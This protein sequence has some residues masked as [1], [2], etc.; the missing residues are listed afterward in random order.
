[1]ERAENGGRDGRL[2]DVPAN[3]GDA[4]GMA[5]GRHMVYVTVASDEPQTLRFIA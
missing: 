1:M 2:T 3:V 5:D 4:E